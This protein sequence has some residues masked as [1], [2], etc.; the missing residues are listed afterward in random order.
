[1]KYTVI[2]LVQTSKCLGTVEA[3]S[4]AEAEDRAQ[5]L[6]C[7]INLCH[8]CSRQFGDCDVIEIVAISE[9]EESACE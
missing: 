9:Q 1:M 8:Q 5:A 4:Q 3:D 7:S 6:D 2:A